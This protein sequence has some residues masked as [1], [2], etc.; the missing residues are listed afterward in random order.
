MKMRAYIN[1]I[2]IVIL[3]AALFLSVVAVILAIVFAAT[4]GGEIPVKFDDAGQ[5]LEY[6]S[7]WDNIGLPLIFLVVNAMMLLFVLVAPVSIWNI[8]VTITEK[9]API[10]YRDAAAMVC[11]IALIFGLMSFIGTVLLY[12]ARNVASGI[13]IAGTASMV[14]TTIVFLIKM[15][16]DGRKYA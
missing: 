10:L 8:P 9:N 14:L 11:V 13:M 5:P 2:H 7:A 15:I 16:V 6:A 4:S 1:K 12:F 3:A